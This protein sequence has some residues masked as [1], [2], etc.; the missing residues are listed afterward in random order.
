MTARAKVVGNGTIGGQEPLGM[1][2]GLEPLHPPLTLA[3]G[4][5]RVLGAVIYIA[6][7]AM[8]D[9]GQHLALGG[10]VAL[11]L[12]SDDDPWDVL[13]AFEQLAEELLGRLLI[14]PAL[15]ED[16]EDIPLLIHS[17]PEIVAFIVNRKKRL[18]HM[19]FVARARSP[20]PQLVR[21]L[22]QKR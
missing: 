8:L 14:P 15:D 13:T 11:E 22:R 5:V 6:V 18:I 9:A 17:P 16:V 10:A 4:L 3:R 12:V 20:A 7:L 21:M 2:R 19:P 1:S